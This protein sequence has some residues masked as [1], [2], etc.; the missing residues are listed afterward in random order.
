MNSDSF[1]PSN[2]RGSLARSFQTSWSCTSRYPIF[3]WYF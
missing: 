3:D 2:S 1:H